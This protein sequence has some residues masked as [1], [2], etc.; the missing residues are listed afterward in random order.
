MLGTRNGGVF[1]ILYMLVSQFGVK[2]TSPQAR[3]AVC[4]SRV[5]GHGSLPV[6]CNGTVFC[7]DMWHRGSFYCIM[8][9]NFGAGCQSDV[10]G[11][12]LNGRH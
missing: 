2:S 4:R 6:V 12:H 9:G 5:P 10:L 1:V 8:C 11:H 7:K 3:E